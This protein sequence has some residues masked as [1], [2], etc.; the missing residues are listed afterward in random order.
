[1]V[2]SASTAVAPH[3]QTES[4]SSDFHKIATFLQSVAAILMP[5]ALLTGRVYQDGL[6]GLRAVLFIFAGLVASR[7]QARV[8]LGQP[9]LAISRSADDE[10]MRSSINH[11]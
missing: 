4:N 9:L 5:V 1:M 10:C 8:R 7:S 3:C 11:G 2:R 6:G